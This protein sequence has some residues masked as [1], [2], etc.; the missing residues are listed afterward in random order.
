MP[1]LPEVETTRRGIAPHVQGAQVQAVR[2]YDPRLRW[3]VPET[4]AAELPGQSIR[5]VERR[6]KYLLLQ[7]ERGCLLLHLGMSGS[8]R[9]LNRTVA[10][11]EHDRLDLCFNSGKLL[12]LRDPRRFGSVH[13]SRDEIRHHPLLARLGPEPLGAEFNGEHLYRR[14]RGRRAAVKSFLMD[15]RNV[16]GIGNIY[17][18]EALFQAGI[19]PSR[20]AGRISRARYQRLADAVRSVLERAIE[21]GG[22]TLRDFVNSAGNPGYFQLQMDVYARGDQPCPRC[23]G[24]IR[25]QRQQ[26]RTSYFCPRCQR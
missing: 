12:R 8:L 22:T 21:A 6:A 23:T 13:W 18:N 16:A 4:L 17:A 25:A 5:Q 3:P 19:S 1:E 26:Q 2:I 20:P 15:G 11:E 10:P 14:S 24:T 9:I 7:A